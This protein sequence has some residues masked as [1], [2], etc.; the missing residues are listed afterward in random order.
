[1]KFWKRYIKQ[2]ELKQRK[3]L[4]QLTGTAVDENG[5]FRNMTLTLFKSYIDDAILG[6]GVI[7]ELG[8]EKP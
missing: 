2:D 3:M 1:M 4:E 5:F 7:S 6:N 8:E